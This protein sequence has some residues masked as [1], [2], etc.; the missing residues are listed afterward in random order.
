MSVTTPLHVPPAV[1]IA[2]PGAAK[3][4]LAAKISIFTLAV[5]NIV[6]VVSHSQVLAA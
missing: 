3:V 5:M 1:S 2:K 4:A 6:A